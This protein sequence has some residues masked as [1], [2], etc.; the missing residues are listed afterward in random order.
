MAITRN[1]TDEVYGPDG[2]I[3]ST[4]VVRDITLDVNTATNLTNLLQDL[5][6]LQAIIHD[7]NANI[8]A[9]PAARIKT[10]ARAQR[11]IIKRLLNAGFDTSAD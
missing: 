5:T 6:D 2:R 8:N 7:T 10:L 11:R 1:D 3:S 4:P 9:N